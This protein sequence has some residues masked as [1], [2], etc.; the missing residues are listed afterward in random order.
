MVMSVARICMLTHR[1]GDS[2]QVI[3][4]WCAKEHHS[5]HF[6]GMEAYF[7]KNLLR[8]IKQWV[9][10]FLVMSR[11]KL[12]SLEVATS[13]RYVKDNFLCDVKF[14]SI[15]WNDLQTWLNVIL[16]KVVDFLCHLII[17]RT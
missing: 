11:Y 16:K 1:T 6:D 12:D 14:I 9:Q 5:T 3:H 8:G 4:E 13:K 7:D 2:N 10:N 15:C 17:L